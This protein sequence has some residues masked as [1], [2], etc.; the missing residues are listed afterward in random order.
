MK[1]LIV[2]KKSKKKMGKAVNSGCHFWHACR[3]LARP[4]L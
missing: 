4:A 1:T 2:Q 3:R